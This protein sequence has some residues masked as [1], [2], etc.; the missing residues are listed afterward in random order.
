MK[1]Y[2]ITDANDVYL[3][4]PFKLV[5]LIYLYNLSGLYGGISFT[6]VVV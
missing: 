6:V 3:S 5:D 4:V 2:L 1:T